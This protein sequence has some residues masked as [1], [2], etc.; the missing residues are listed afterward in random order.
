MICDLTTV[1]KYKTTKF[2]M[3]NGIILYVILVGFLLYM[4]FTGMLMK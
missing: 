2:E 4:T 1:S 3:I